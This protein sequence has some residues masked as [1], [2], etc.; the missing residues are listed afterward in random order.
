MEHELVKAPHSSLCMV[1]PRWC[2]GLGSSE[3]ARAYVAGALGT[4][5]T[6]VEECNARDAACTSKHVLVPPTSRLE[7][8]HRADRVRA[9]HTETGRAEHA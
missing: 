9:K 2:V 4:A 6:Y 3:V 5:G 7:L 8:P 1:V